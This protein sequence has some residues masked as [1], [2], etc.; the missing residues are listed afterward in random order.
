MLSEG[1]GDPNCYREKVLT[2]DEVLEK[3]RER[4]RR[5]KAKQA[6]DM[7]TDPGVA[8]GIVLAAATGGVLGDVTLNSAA[9]TVRLLGLI[10]EN[11]VLGAVYTG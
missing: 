1:R 8:S 11:P 3:A 7:T 10:N 5:E 6:F 4:T 2:N 9:L